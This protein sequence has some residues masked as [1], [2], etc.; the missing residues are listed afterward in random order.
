MG[1]IAQRPVNKSLN[2]QMLELAIQAEKIKSDPALRH[3]PNE[4]DIRKVSE[5][6]HLMHQCQYET[7]KP[8]SGEN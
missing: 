5:N 7:I 8:E 2:K 1:A 6:T 4:N 3:A